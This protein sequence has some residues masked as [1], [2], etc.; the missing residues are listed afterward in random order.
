MKKFLFLVVC[1]LAFM[2]YAKA[3]DDYKF[4]AGLFAD[5]YRLGATGTNMWGIGGRAGLELLPH[6]G[7]EGELAFDF[8]RGFTNAFE[9][10]FGGTSYVTSG[11]RDLHGL[12]G[13]RFSFDH[14]PIRPF[15]EAKFG[16]DSFTFNNIPTGLNSISNP[17]QNLR[18]QTLNPA[19]FLGGGVEAKIKGH[20]AVRLDI[21]DEIYFNSGAQNG[22]KVT[23]GPVVR[24]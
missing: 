17:I 4:D 8:N 1:L 12:F 6:I 22:L 7:F 2:P 24:F 13:P 11:V 20:V 10:S 19:L 21:G 9:N 15:V 16:F 18:N 14:G 5:Y 3:Q 23:F